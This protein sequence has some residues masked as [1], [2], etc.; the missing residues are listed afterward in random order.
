MTDREVEI[1]RNAEEY[2]ALMVSNSEKEF[3]SNSQF[4]F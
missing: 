2:I 3:A 1:A 4:S